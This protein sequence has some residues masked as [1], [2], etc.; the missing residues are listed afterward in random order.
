MQVGIS[1]ER[2]MRLHLHCDRCDFSL[3]RLV[4]DFC[5][6][7]KISCSQPQF[8]AFLEAEKF[9]NRSFRVQIK[10]MLFRRFYLL[11]QEWHPSMS[12]ELALFDWKRYKLSALRKEKLFQ[13]AR[14]WSEAVK[15]TSL[16]TLRM[17]IQ[18]SS[19]AKSLLRFLRLQ[20]AVCTLMPF[21]G[22]WKF[23]RSKCY[24]MKPKILL[25]SV[26]T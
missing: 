4:K 11:V 7:H 3:T 19:M 10:S 24:L 13:E 21:C 15:R 1:L 20:L 8:L 2:S 22:R 16:R 12:M 6:W 17:Q 5:D 23:L 9:N 14:S 18:M 26:L 25:G